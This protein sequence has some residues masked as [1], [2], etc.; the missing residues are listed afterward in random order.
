MRADLGLLTLLV[1]LIAVSISVVSLHRTRKTA[2]RQLELQ[3]AQS[4][5]AEFQHKV[6]TSQQMAARRADLRVEVVRDRGQPQFEFSNLGP[7]SAKDVVCKF[8]DTGARRTPVIGEQFDRAF[9][10][11]EFMPGSKFRL[12]AVFTMDT[13]P[14][15]EGEFSW[16]NVDGNTESRVC[17]IVR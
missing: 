13:P 15:L 10:I 5:L 8:G 1:S 11:K 16:V 4:K 3:E 7:A 12:A 2:A 14:V 17:R 6:L 9:P